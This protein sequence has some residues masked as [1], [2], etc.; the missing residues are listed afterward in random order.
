MP[1]NDRQVK[2]AKPR[3]KDYKLADEK[4]LYLLV[5]VN[6]SR[7]WRLKYRFNGKEKTLSIG[8]YPDVSTGDGALGTVTSTAGVQAGDYVLTIT[9]A[10]ADA[11]VFQL[12]DP[13]GD[14]AGVGTVGTAFTGGGL[15][16]TLADGA[17]DF[18]VG[19]SFTIT[20]ESS[21]LLAEW[22][23]ANTDGTDTVAGILFAGVDATSGN[24]RGVLVARKAVVTGGD[25]T[26]FDGVTDTDKAAAEEQLNKLGII[27]G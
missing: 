21:G 14:V 16:F 26:Y 10:Q 24:K 19:D 3:D 23:P 9:A 20:V 1:L 6:G 4:G 18:A 27:V 7:Y 25:L 5:K 8:V 11:G 17:T 22:N 12:V 13:Q 2:A 15:S